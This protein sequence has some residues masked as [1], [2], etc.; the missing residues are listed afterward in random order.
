MSD[1]RYFYNAKA[2]V[3]DSA[4]YCVTKAGQRKAKRGE[5]LHAE[6]RYFIKWLAIARLEGPVN[7]HEVDHLISYY[8]GRPI[9]RV[10]GSWKLS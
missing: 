4:D 2:I 6:D 8:T 7:W 9:Q 10:N 5:L 3:I 1:S